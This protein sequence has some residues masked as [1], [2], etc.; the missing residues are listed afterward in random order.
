MISLSMGEAALGASGIRVIISL[1]GPRTGAWLMG[2]SGLELPWFPKLG[3]PCHTVRRHQKTLARIT[4]LLGW[5]E[6]EEQGWL[7]ASSGAP[8]SCRE[9]EQG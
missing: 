7:V 6:G 8:W 1:E 2:C 3:F 5:A 4:G 9:R